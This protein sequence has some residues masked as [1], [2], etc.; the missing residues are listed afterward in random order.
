MK[1]EN[2]A[3]GD[4]LIN[5]YSLKSPLAEVVASMRERIENGKFTQEEATDY[6]VNRA[7]VEAG[8]KDRAME[9]C[10]TLRDRAKFAASMVFD[11]EKTP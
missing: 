10:E 1:I 6:L 3:S 11:W 2:N 7:W 9:F 4:P 8:A 5:G